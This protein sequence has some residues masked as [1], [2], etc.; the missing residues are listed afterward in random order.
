M[1]IGETNSPAFSGSQYFSTHD[2]YIFKFKALIKAW[3]LQLENVT[4][5]SGEIL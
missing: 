2:S 1:V 3:V 4:I 5:S